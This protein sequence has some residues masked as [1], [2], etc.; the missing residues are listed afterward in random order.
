[1]GCAHEPIASGALRGRKDL[2]KFPK[3]ALEEAPGID[4]V[5][6]QRVGF[7]LGK[8]ADSANPGIDAVGQREIDNPKIA[9]E[10]NRGLRAP[11][12]QFM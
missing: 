2:D 8:H 9:T 12:R 11:L 1:M 3:I 7:V 5:L 10:I 6:D 4:Q